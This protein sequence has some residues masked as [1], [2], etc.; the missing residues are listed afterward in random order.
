MREIKERLEQEGLRAKRTSE[1]K[2]PGFKGPEFVNL[3]IVVLTD[4]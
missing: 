2:Q 4:D 1:G 3:F